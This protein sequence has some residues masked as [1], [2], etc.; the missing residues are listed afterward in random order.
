V[1]PFVGRLADRVGPV[2]PATLGLA[3]QIVAML[4]YA[5]LALTTPLWVVSATSIVNGLGSG[6]FF[7]ANNAAVMKAAP[8]QVFGVASGLLRTFAN[9]GMVFSFSTAL[10]VAAH[11]LSRGLAFAIFVGNAVVAGRAG[12]AFLTGIHA[13]LLASVIAF[14]VAGVLSALRATQRPGPLSAGD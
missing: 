1:A 12:A 7:P 6:S 11:A 3:V 2:L 10:L 14:A 4:L 13:S 8:R 9:V 5:H